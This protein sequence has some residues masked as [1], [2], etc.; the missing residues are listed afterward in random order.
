[1]KV[2]SGG[3]SWSILEFSPSPKSQWKLK[4]CSK[5]M[6]GD[7]KNGG[8]IQTNIKNAKKNTNSK[9]PCFPPGHLPPSTHPPPA[10]GHQPHEFPPP[11][12][13]LGCWPSPCLGRWPGPAAPPVPPS[14]PPRSAPGRR[15]AGEVGPRKGRAPGPHHRVGFGPAVRSISCSPERH[16]FVD[17]W[18]GSNQPLLPTTL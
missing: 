10:Q 16:L 2:C 14:P 3:N 12:P 4:K 18:R 15:G 8:K 11:A 9:K 17:I 5:K 6:R 7:T 13:A 1:M